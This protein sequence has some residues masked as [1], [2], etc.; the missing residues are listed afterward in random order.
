MSLKVGCVERKWLRECLRIGY[1]F[2][3][4]NEPIMR[5]NFSHESFECEPSHGVALVLFVGNLSTFAAIGK[6]MEVVPGCGVLAIS[7][8]VVRWTALGTFR[9]V[10][11]FIDTCLAYLT[12]LAPISP[13]SLVLFVWVCTNFHYHL[14]AHLLPSHPANAR[15]DFF[16]LALAYLDVAWQESCVSRC[17][18][19]F[20]V[21]L[22][23]SDCCGGL[24]FASF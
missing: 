5:P 4:P 23:C 15:S 19:A 9:L 24:A 10:V 6:S 13:D 18:A 3:A 20:E 14:G 1:A 21:A 8:Y 7:R 11:C 16:D 17:L 12:G 22:A 2:G